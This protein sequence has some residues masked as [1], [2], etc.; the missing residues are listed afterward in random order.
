MTFTFGVTAPK[1]KSF[2]TLTAPFPTGHTFKAPGG[3]WKA[4]GTQVWFA[5]LASSLSGSISATFDNV[6]AGTAPG[7]TYW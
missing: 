7:A 1:G 5:P 3:P 6:S 4:I 2:V